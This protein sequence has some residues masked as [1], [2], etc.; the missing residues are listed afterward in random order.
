M[1]VHSLITRLRQSRL[2]ADSLWALLGS[3]M[4]KGLSLLAGIAIARLLG[5][6]LYGEYGTVKSTLLMIAVF[7]SLGLGYSATKFIA[8]SRTNGNDHR[9]VDTH[10]VATIVTLITS[11][12]IALAI[13]LLAD[14]VAALLDAPHLA[15]TLRISSVAIVFNAINTTQTGELAGFGAY[16]ELAA[17]N[18]W[19]GIFT[20]VTS[21][22]L[23][24]LYGFDGAIIALIISLLFNAILNHRTLR[25][26]L[27]NYAESRHINRAYMGE[28]VRFSIPIALQESLY[29]ITNWGQIYILVTLA[30]FSEYGISS[31]AH[32]WMSVLLF[33]PGAL[34]NVA[35]SHLSATNNDGERNR[36]ILRRLMLV[37][38]CSTFAPFVV[39]FLLSGWIASWYGASFEGLQPVLNVCVLTAVVSSLSNVLTQEFMAH[40]RNWFLFWSRLLRDIG[41]LTT[42]YIAICCFGH[43][44][45]AAAISV[46][47]WQSG[48]L[49][50]L[51]FAQTTKLCGPRQNKS[52]N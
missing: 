33:I 8:E 35:L 40:G 30:D 1:N 51:L 41:A 18:T 22:G 37:N 46:L 12:I 26:L 19:S 10:R 34:R 31:A 6:E 11:C 36:A 23:T 13:L 4:G 47:V 44:A 43:A 25:R 48:Y 49:I 7:S 32:Q 9:I 5:S 27:A 21:I 50:V 29:T 52:D 2:F 16:R 20:F 17:N 45:L 42:T 15:H 24:L 38:F 3:A 28:V 39:I 14:K